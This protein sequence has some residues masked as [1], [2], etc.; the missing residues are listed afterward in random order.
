M[1]KLIYLHINNSDVCPNCQKKKKSGGSGK[2]LMYCSS[3]TKTHYP[4]YILLHYCI[5]IIIVTQY[6]VTP[7]DDVLELC[8][9]IIKDCYV[10]VDFWRIMWHW[11]LKMLLKIQLCIAW[12]KTPF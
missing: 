4:W 11:R 5:V 6:I 12:I 7:L 2:G 1:F 9:F 10:F 3:D 8:L